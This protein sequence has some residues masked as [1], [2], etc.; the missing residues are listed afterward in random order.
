MNDNIIVVDQNDREIGT[1]EKLAVHRDGVLHRAFSVFIF[2]YRDQMLLQQRALA[3]YHS[4]GLW[5][6]ACCS[7]PR[8]GESIE[9]ASERRLREEMR[10]SCP[11]LKAFDFIYRAELDHE[12]TEHEFDHVLIGRYEGHIQPD[13]SEVMAHRWISLYRLERE[14]RHVPEK[15][16]VWFKIAVNKVIRHQH[17]S[18]FADLATMVR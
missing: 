2:N 15:F 17:H 13:P 4:G 6:N 3:K 10:I 14:L 11:L 12:L 5:S 1:A 7:H 9:E 16:T 18:A 8:P